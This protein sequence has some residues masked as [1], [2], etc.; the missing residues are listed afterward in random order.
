VTVEPRPSATL[1][2]GL[3][4]NIARYR[5]RVTGGDSWGRFLWQGLVLSLLA[6]CPTILA[7]MLRG[8]V[9]RTVLGSLGSSCMIESHVRLLVPGRIFLGRHVL[10]G[11]GCFLDAHSLQ[12]RIDLGDDVWLSRGCY[13]VAYRDA[14]VRI[15]ER[16]YI[17]HRC[18]LYG[19][20]GI[21]IG[22]DALL[23]N[24]VQLICGNHTFGRRDIP[25]RDQPG[26]QKPIVVGD[27]VWLGA[28]AIVLGGV[29]IGQ[30][31]VVGAGAVVTHGL[32]PYSIARGVPAKVVGE[33]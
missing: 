2:G 6:D 15:G 16:A 12:G 11:E 25:I 32:P 21:D 28:S 24:D 3:R 7:S 14:E 5:R 18:L 17:G 10:V 26:E 19:H 33:R 4:Q 13:V 20:G 27:D 22:R 30:G 9:Y 8:R 31:A 29:T 23:A 1:Q